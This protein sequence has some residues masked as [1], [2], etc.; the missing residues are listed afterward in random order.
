M[1]NS[2]YEIGQKVRSYATGSTGSKPTRA[3]FQSAANI[4]TYGL[5]L[6]SVNGVVVN[7]YSLSTAYDKAER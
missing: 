1:M 7:Q 2:I 5:G 3:G 4:T 6:S